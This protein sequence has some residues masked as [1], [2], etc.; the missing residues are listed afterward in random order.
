MGTHI[1]HIIPKHMGGTNDPDN[2]IELTVEEHAEAHRLLY[3]EHGHWQDH[4]AWK[5]LSG[6]ITTDEAR[7]IATIT[8]WTGRNHTEEAKE[9]I[10][11]ARKKQNS[12]G[13]KWSEEARKRRSEIMSG[14][15]L[16]PERREKISKSMKNKTKPK[17][18]CPHCNKEGGAPQMI[19]WHFDNC[20]QRDF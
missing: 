19:Q 3:E 4:L 11:A 2:L 20:K 6:Q 1:H 10:R 18:I 8:T 7:R 16:S 14:K 12:R 15:T 13:W 5:A 17:L 9:K